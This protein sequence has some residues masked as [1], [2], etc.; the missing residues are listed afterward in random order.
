MEMEVNVSINTRHRTSIKHVIE[1]ADGHYGPRWSLFASIE[2]GEIAH[3]EIGVPSHQIGKTGVWFPFDSP[4]FDKMAIAM[5]LF[6]ARVKEEQEKQLSEMYEARQAID[7]I[8]AFRQV[9]KEEWHK[10]KLNIQ[11]RAKD[12]YNKLHPNE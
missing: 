6:M 9:T 12:A 3:L 8:N 1:N 10:N 7:Q 11:Q 4:V 5:P 2:N